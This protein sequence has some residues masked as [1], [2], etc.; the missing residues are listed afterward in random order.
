MVLNVV[1][2]P[3]ED[4]TVLMR[5]VAR[6]DADEADAIEVETAVGFDR[7]L[8]VLYLMQPGRKLSLRNQSF[9]V[10]TDEG[11]ELVGI[12]HP[13]VDRIEIGPGCSADFA[14][15]D[16]ALATD[17]DVA[18]VDFAGV[19]RGLLLRR[20]DDRAPLQLAQ[21]RTV[22]DPDMAVALARKL[23]EAR[24]RNQRTQL[25]RLN[26][27]A[28]DP[29]VTATLAAMQRHL[30]KLPGHDT[31][32]GLRGIEGV[33]AAEYWPAL[34]RMI[35]GAEGPFRR[36]RPALDAPNAAINYL[37]AILERDMLAAVLSVGLHPG[38]GV[39]HAARDGGQAAVYDLME[40]F[41]APL[42]EGLV[43]FLLN[44]RRLRS[45]MF[46]PVEGGVRISSAGREALI[47]GY[48]TSVA[49]QVNAP[50][51]GTGRK[52]R[53][54]WRAMMR[55]QAQDFAQACRAGNPTL[56]HPYLMEQ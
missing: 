12:A 47:R 48:E 42:T 33:T 24:I 22:S 21:A 27:D 36:Q 14:A 7:R 13:R 41:R 20:H 35:E 5:Q 26:H 3:E 19:T 8:R 43:V 39:L 51:S 31:V 45:D 40:P 44:A 15:L 28:A 23:V 18:V 55:R 10:L 53:L 25:F 6:D 46:N 54:G 16:H 49:R 52:V 17:T 32:E 11:Q 9:T 37:T 38:F 4:P 29:D 56:F 2:D 30:R 50:A 34:G 1:S